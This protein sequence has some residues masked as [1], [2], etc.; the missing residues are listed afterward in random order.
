MGR[1]VF[2]P[3][4]SSATGDAPSS[5]RRPSPSSSPFVAVRALPSAA[6]VPHLLPPPRSRTETLLPRPR[7]RRDRLLRHQAPLRSPRTRPRTLH[8]ERRPGRVL[9]A[10]SVVAFTLGPSRAGTLA[11]ARPRARAGVPTCA[12]V[13]AGEDYDRRNGGRRRGWAAADA[14][15]DVGRAVGQGDGAGSAGRETAAA[16]FWR[17]R[18]QMGV[19]R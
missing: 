19:R 16:G 11:L 15:R 1:V 10:H 13:G 17:R 6:N 8:E 14:R 2:V 18:G 9:H 5:G 3:A 12:G 4:S 7:V